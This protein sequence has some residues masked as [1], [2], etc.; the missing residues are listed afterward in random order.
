MRSE[1]KS[2]LFK[3][4]RIT[5]ARVHNPDTVPLSPLGAYLSQARFRGFRASSHV[6][7]FRDL[8]SKSFVKFSM[9]SYERAGWLSSRDLGDSNRYL[10]KRAGNFCHM[11]TSARLFGMKTGLIWR[12]GCIHR[13]ALPAVFSTS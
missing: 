3:K 10:D 8:A 9:G 5:L 4:T 12:P 1:R 11:N 2:C 7:S 13:L 6:P